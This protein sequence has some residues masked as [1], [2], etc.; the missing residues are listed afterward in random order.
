MGLENLS[1][2]D[3]EESGTKAAEASDE[4]FRDKIR[5]TQKA[6]RALKKA[7]GKA[8]AKDNRLAKVIGKFLQTHSNTAV[9]LLI[10]RCLDHNIPAG[11]ILGILALVE[12]EAQKEFEMMLDE[13]AQL[14]EA[15][16]AG[17]RALATGGKFPPEIKQTLDVW[18]FGL[19]EFGLTQPTRLL[20]TAISPE[21]KLFPSLWK[22]TAFILRDFFEKK[23]LETEFQKTEEFAEFVLRN[24]LGKIKIQLEETKELEG[25]VE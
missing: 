14:L 9:M 4:V 23:K 25:G 11:L 12:A 3:N 16:K 21:D 24:V 10:S 20:A 2:L 7:E 18:S 22:L 15:P 19:L 5:K 1:P 17:N 13:S 6:Q 8:R